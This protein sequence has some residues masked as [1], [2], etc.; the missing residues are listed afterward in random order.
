MNTERAIPIHAI[1]H[2]KAT[3]KCCVFHFSIS[4]I[5]SWL[6]LAPLVVGK[7][8]FAYVKTHWKEHK[9]SLG[10][11]YIINIRPLWNNLPGIYPDF[12]ETLWREINDMEAKWPV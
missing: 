10:S 6:V 4:C 12:V 7:F 1:C 5:T 2:D 11:E 3:C 8:V 9:T